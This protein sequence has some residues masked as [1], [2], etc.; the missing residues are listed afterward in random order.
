M[1]PLLPVFLRHLPLRILTPLLRFASLLSFLDPSCRRFPSRGVLVA[2]WAR[3]IVAERRMLNTSIAAP[4]VVV[5]LEAAFAMDVVARIAEQ[6]SPSCLSIPASPLRRSWRAGLKAF[7][8]AC[9]RARMAVYPRIVG[10]LCVGAA[11]FASPLLWTAFDAKKLLAANAPLKRD[12]QLSVCIPKAGSIAAID[13]ASPAGGTRSLDLLFIASV[14]SQLATFLTAAPFALAAMAHIVSAADAI[15]HVGAA[16]P[17]AAGQLIIAA[18][19]LISMTV[20]ESLATAREAAI[21]GC[22]VWRA[23]GVEA[24]RHEVSA[25]LATAHL[26]LQR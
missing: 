16:E 17:R 19:A 3:A 5:E 20:T 18:R 24:R 7:V 25:G 11:T 8:A 23:R 14:A 26:C 10:P 4:K 22:Q 21:E 9:S 2:V 12:K 13:T 1:P 6:P 15:H